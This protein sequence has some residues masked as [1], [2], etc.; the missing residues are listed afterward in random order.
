MLLVGLRFVVSLVWFATEEHTFLNANIKE[1]AEKK[2]LNWCF[3]SKDLCI[4]D[5][6][7]SNGP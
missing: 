6:T 2:L 5:E 4:Y 1:E 7:S 3:F